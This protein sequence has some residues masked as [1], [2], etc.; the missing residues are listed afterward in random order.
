[1]MNTT[2]SKIRKALTTAV[3]GVAEPQIQKIGNSRIIVELPGVSNPVEV[4]KLLEGTALL[5]FKLVYDPQKA[6]KVME[7]INKVLVGDT[8]ALKDSLSTPVKTSSIDSSNKKTESVT[9]NDTSKKSAASEKNVSD[10]KKSAGNEVSKDSIKEK[11]NNENKIVKKDSIKDKKD[12][13]KKTD[14]AIT[15]NDTN[16]Q[17]DSANNQ[18][19]EEEF[20]KKYPF[21]TLVTLN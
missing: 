4:R 9:S 3:T 20:K 7:A 15:T 10:L 6:V 19:S 12:S 13:S 8:T 21:F 2:F 1:M 5:E 14:S 11:K 16:T 17:S 18:L